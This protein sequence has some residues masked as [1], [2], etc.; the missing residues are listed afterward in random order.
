M[1]FAKLTAHDLDD[2]EQDQWVNLERVL[3]IRIVRRKRNGKTTTI[4]RLFFGDK[5]VDVIETPEEILT[6]A[7]S[8]KA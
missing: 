6:Q 8:M 7:F 5:T 3:Y 2:N 1:N 4:S